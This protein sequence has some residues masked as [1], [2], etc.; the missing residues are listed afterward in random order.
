MRRRAMPEVLAWFLILL[1][2]C[3]DAGLTE[4][5]LAAAVV[6]N[7]LTPATT[8]TLVIEVTGAG[9]DPGFVVNVPVG[10]DSVAR[11]MLSIPSGSSRRFEV[12]AV[13]T[14]GVSTHSGVASVNLV[15]GPNPPLAITLAPLSSS[16]GITITFGSLLSD[17]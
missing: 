15:P 13:D 6:V 9:I 10:A 4:P 14:A 11:G 8:R 1:T 16:V 17:R 5:R 12:T 3:A 7:A 2:G